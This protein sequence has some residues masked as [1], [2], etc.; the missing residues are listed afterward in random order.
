MR[1]SVI[2]IDGWIA[3]DCSDFILVQCGSRVYMFTICKSSDVALSPTLVSRCRDNN[4][5]TDFDKLFLDVREFIYSH[6]NLITNVNKTGMLLTA[7]TDQLF[8]ANL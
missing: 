1:A 4:K 5:F 7:F 2:R 6:C 8:F 3:L